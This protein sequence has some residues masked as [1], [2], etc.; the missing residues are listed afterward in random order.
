[1]KA[2]LS[3]LQVSSLARS[4]KVFGSLELS[5]AKW[6]VAAGDGGT[7]VSEY[8]VIAGDG[9]GLLRIIERARGHFGLTR[10]ARV[11]SCYEAGRDGFW[12]HR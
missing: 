12:L 10:D 4:E 6:H 1:M 9:P 3:A 7:R 8:T 11:V 2:K 5:N